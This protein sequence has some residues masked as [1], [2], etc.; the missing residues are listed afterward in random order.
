MYD[1]FHICTIEGYVGSTLTNKHVHKTNFIR[2]FE[3]IKLFS[4]LKIIYFFIDT[5]SK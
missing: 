3:I 2:I 4:N 1:K 5:I